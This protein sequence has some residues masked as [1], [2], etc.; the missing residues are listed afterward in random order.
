MLLQNLH[1]NCWSDQRPVQRRC[2]SVVRR[3][4]NVAPELVQ[5]ERSCLADLS[6]EELE[7][8][9]KLHGVLQLTMM[10]LR[11]RLEIEFL[12]KLMIMM[13]TQAYMSST[14]RCTLTILCCLCWSQAFLCKLVCLK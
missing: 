12:S 14:P 2:S 9:L 3:T 1:P 7:L 5:L 6:T 13:C 8:Q 11:P 4:A 10:M